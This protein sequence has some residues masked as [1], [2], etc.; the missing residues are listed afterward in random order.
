VRAP[1]SFLFRVGPILLFFPLT[2]LGYRRFF[3]VAFSTRLIR[4]FLCLLVFPLFFPL[5]PFFE[6]LDGY[7]PGE[8]SHSLWSFFSDTPFS[9]PTVVRRS[10]L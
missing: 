1:F 4:G 5:V 10:L 9:D 3:G 8:V 6:V 2:L 7:S